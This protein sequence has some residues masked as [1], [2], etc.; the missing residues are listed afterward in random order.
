MKKEEQRRINESVEDFLKYYNIEIEKHPVTSASRLRTC[1]A[2]VYDSDFFLVLKSYNTV[3]AVI[4][5]DE[6]ILYDFSRLVY[7][8]T[9]T[10]A[11]HI[12]KF[13]NDYDV[14]PSDRYIWKEVK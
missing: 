5:K 12:A 7:G 1:K 2:V 9:A 6:G 14:P 3:V 10:T 4:D 13:A 11:K 8:Y